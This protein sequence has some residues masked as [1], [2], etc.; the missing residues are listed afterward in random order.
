MGKL[1]IEN[2]PEDLLQRIEHDAK[3]AHREPSEVAADWLAFGAVHRATC[4]PLKS[5]EELLRLADSVRTGEGNAWFTNEFI[6]A[7]REDGRA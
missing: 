5:A 3:Q 1:L 7:A 4:G 2:L 6:R